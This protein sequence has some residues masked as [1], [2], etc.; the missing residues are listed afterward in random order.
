MDV[1]TLAFL[2]T[3]PAN[4][5]F[6]NNLFLQDVGGD[7]AGDGAGEGDGEGEGEGDGEGEGEGDGEGDGE[8]E[9]EGEGEGPTPSQETVAGLHCPSLPHYIP[10]CFT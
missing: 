3:L 9:G 1:F 4:C 5:L 10:S 8:G 6:L 2:F 7:G